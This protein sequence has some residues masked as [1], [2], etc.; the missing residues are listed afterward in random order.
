MRAAA[1]AARQR[2]VS[3]SGATYKRSVSEKYIRDRAVYAYSGQQ[4]T[5]C[6]HSLKRSWSRRCCCHLATQTRSRARTHTRM[7]P[8]VIDSGARVRE[9]KKYACLRN[10]RRRRVGVAPSRIY[11]LMLVFGSPTRLSKTL[12]VLARVCVCVRARV[13]MRSAADYRLLSFLLNGG[14]LAG[15]AIAWVTTRAVLCV[16]ARARTRRLVSKNGV[17]LLLKQR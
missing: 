4:R 6:C 7:P 8:C 14:H 2:S 3:T 12:L 5:S 15:L 1:A 11:G 10:W 16:C 9:Y 13:T 17:Y